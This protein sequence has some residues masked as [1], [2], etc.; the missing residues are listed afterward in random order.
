[1][2]YFDRWD[3][4]EAHLAFCMDYHS[5]QSSELYRR[6]C[7]ITDPKGKI[8]FRPSPLWKGFNSLSENAREI[9]RQLEEKNR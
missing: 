8:Q 6:M 2:P 7:R 4:A 3:I 1:M 5:G 9:Y